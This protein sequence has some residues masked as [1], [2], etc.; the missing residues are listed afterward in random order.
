MPDVIVK[1]LHLLSLQAAAVVAVPTENMVMES[2]RA[3][4]LLKSEPCSYTLAM[5]FSASVNT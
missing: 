1:Q 5:N 4:D 3:D 2:T